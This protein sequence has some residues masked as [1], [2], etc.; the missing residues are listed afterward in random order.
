M[1]V[2]QTNDHVGL[3]IKV[4]KSKRNILIIPYT[5][6]VLLSSMAMMK[7]VKLSPLEV[8][9]KLVPANEYPDLYF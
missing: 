8:K 5:Y 9:I 7:R 6:L 2:T 3:S 4:W 1:T